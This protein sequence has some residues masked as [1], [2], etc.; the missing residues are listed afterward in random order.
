MDP[1]HEMLTSIFAECYSRW[2]GRDTLLVEIDEGTMNEGYASRIQWFDPDLIYS[3]VPLDIPLLCELERRT[4]PAIIEQHRAPDLRPRL[5]ITPLPALSALPSVAVSERPFARKPLAIV[6]AY[7][8]WRDPDLFV[9]D[10]FGVNPRSPGWVGA[11]IVRDY[12]E[13]WAL[14][15]RPASSA[16]IADRDFSDATDLLRAMSSSEDS[17]LTMASL[18][19]M[20]A[21]DMIIRDESSW[22]RSFALVVGDSSRERLAFWNGRLACPEWQRRN[23]V[24]LRVPASRLRDDDFMTAL[25][26]YAARANTFSSQSGPHL[27]TIRSASISSPELSSLQ[28]RLQER[29]VYTRIEPFEKALDALSPEQPLRPAS[30]RS[31]SEQR[32]TES[33]FQ[34]RVKGPRHLRDAGP[35]PPSFASGSWVAR[36]KFAREGRT[37]TFRS[38]DWLNLPRR[39]QCIPAFVGA[40][41]PSK[42]DYGGA[43]SVVV[44]DRDNPAT[45][46]LPQDDARFV[47]AMLM[48][49]YYPTTV[50]P[51]NILIADAPR[52]YPATSDKGRHLFG[53]LQ[54]FGTVAHAHEVLTNQYW[55]GVFRAMAVPRENRQEAKR[56]AVSS[57]LKKFFR[58]RSIE[59]LRADK[60]WNNLAEAVIH[61]AS[62]LK[63]P[64]L[65]ESYEWFWAEYQRLVG[66][67]AEE[68]EF[69]RQLQQRCAE[70]LL[71]QGYAW[72]CARCLHE[73]WVSVDELRRSV[74]CV[75]CGWSE[76]ILP[77]FSWSFHLDEFF[78]SALREH[79]V[80]GVI[81]ALGHLNQNSREGF[82]FSPP[83]NLI[84]EDAKAVWREIDIVCIADGKLLIGE[85]KES[86]NNFG[87]G[88][89]ARITEVAVVIRPDIVVL[90]CLQREGKERLEKHAAVM[91][92][93]LDPLGVRVWPI[94]PDARFGTMDTLI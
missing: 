31:S 81:W 92:K 75:V 63:T 78:G 51:R 14:G 16:F 12:A 11:E 24:A 27:A 9:T 65:I 21:D 5:G 7:N 64:S 62:G 10:S 60:D 44:N 48:Q 57:R 54:R 13:H 77:K 86:M 17:V 30:Y 1:P 83:L 76:D 46:D 37:G 82:M 39:W 84:R 25:V 33:S 68:V 58:S 49:R 85:V 73:N 34:V 50:D 52:L 61:I 94:V 38:I 56:S 6:G 8:E 18:G 45:L 89:I 80:L 26:E 2:G 59:E 66:A 93:S 22:G 87:A 40:A 4:M 69:K 42:I 20:A 3:F 53:V 43:L 74:E 71:L 55:Q 15:S 88:E 79:G 41:A 23:I 28:R 19:A 91:R 32:V 29:S 67:D 36:L 47:S 35:V 70:G 90:A 72:R